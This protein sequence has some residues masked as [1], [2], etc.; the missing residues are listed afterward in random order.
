[1]I[2]PLLIDIYNEKNST[3][4]DIYYSF[5]K[6][7]CIKQCG[8]ILEN[9]TFDRYH[10]CEDGIILSFSLDYHNVAEELL[11]IDL[12]KRFY[13]EDLIEFTI[14]ICNRQIQDF[15]DFG[16]TNSEYLDGHN[17]SDYIDCRDV[18]EVYINS[19]VEIISRVRKLKIKNLLK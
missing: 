8:Y 2:S 3:I 9:T 12:E 1:M 14:E 19:M 15:E 17:Y 13:T 6:D 18:E 16:I 4:E 5:V 11:D 10:D 7:Y